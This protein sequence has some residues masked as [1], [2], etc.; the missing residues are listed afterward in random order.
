MS[1]EA[2]GKTTAGHDLTIIRVIDAPRSLVWKAWTD[3]A[4]LAQWWGPHGW[5]APV[6]RIEA[7]PGGVWHIDMQ[8][9][10][11][12]IYPCR[13]RYLDVVDNQRLVYSDVVHADETAW[14]GKPPPSCVQ[15]IAFEDVGDRTRLAITMRMASAAD[16]DAMANMGC[17]AGWTESIERL[18]ELLMRMQQHA[19]PPM[20][21]SASGGE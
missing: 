2:L 18:N 21:H 16:R 12:T 7:R 20:T 13:G 17:E 1:I 3:E 15:V 9:P 10:D 8:G 6:C 11:G 4:L 19:T 5:A 14:G